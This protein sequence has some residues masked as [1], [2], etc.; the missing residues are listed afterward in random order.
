MF[1]FGDRSLVVPKTIAEVEDKYCIKIAAAIE[2]TKKLANACLEPF[3]KQVVGLLIYGTR[4]ENRR[5]CPHEVEKQK[6][7][8]HFECIG[9]NLA[10]LHD[11]MDAMIDKLETIRDR[12]T[13]KN[14]ILPYSCCFFHEF[15]K[16]CI[17]LKLLTSS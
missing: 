12:D 4:K 11:A 7:V 9:H 8:T 17:V 3:P 1:Q 14:L 5:V 10:P 6:V 15:R 13:D 16:V 2:R